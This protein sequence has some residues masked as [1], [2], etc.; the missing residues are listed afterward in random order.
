MRD[1][2]IEWKPFLAV[3]YKISAAPETVTIITPEVPNRV[4]PLTRKHIKYSS[5]GNHCLQDA[6][7]TKGSK[8][9]GRMGEIICDINRSGLPT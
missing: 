5:N 2:S 8:R 6:A 9:D 4:R 7:G 3:V 1:K